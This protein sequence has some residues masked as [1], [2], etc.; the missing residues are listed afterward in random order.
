MD[1][2]I[3]ELVCRKTASF[4]LDHPIASFTFDDFPSSAYRVGGRILEDFN[5]RGTYYTSLG[6]QGT[7]GASGEYF[8]VSDLK[9]AYINGHELAC[10][11]FSHKTCYQSSASKFEQ[12]VAMNAGHI[13]EQIPGLHFQTF[14]Y[15]QGV[16]SPLHHQRV[17]SRFKCVRTIAK[18]VNRG[19]FNLN[20]LRA[21][22]L[23]ETTFSLAALANLAEDLRKT[24]G[25]V[26]FYTHD[27]SDA[28]SRYGVTP[29]LL[30][31]TISQILSSGAQVLP[32]AD[33]L[34]AIVREP[35]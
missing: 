14:A 1:T 23:Y 9:D 8:S 6:L 21:I 30:E 28:P 32:V 15:P 4:T 35:R 5:L 22:Q 10:H 34:N 25:W 26:V 3:C 29:G 7:S 17:S 11:T 13:S 31:A 19:I 12:D 24:P 18:G 20:F 2:K 33:A 16:V 27:V